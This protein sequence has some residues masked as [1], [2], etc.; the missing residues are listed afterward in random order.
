MVK[1]KLGWQGHMRLVAT[2]IVAHLNLLI[3][4]IALPKKVI[5][6][7]IW[8]LGNIKGESVLEYGCGVGSLTM[9]LIQAVGQKGRVYATGFIMP[10]LSITK[11]RLKRRYH[12]NVLV[13]D[14]PYHEHRVHPHVNKVDAIVSVSMLPYIKINKVLKDMNKKLDVGDEICFLEHDKLLGFV[15]NVNWI[16]SNSKIKYIF[17]NA[18]FV[19]KVKR[20]SG[21]AWE[22]VYIY[23]KK[24]KNI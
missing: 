11:V 13:L 18:G 14:D 15:S 23:G 19:V 7:I 2:T 17:R 4:R 12:K 22:Y 21:F 16:K 24:V 10:E 20:E 9:H 6:K 8:L 3:E 1:S 5:N